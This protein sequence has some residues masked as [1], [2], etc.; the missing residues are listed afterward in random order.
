MSTDVVDYLLK[1][2]GW[3]ETIDR[4]KPHARSFYATVHDRRDLPNC[5]CNEKPPAVCL[6]EYPPYPGTNH[7]TFEVEICGEIKGTWVK[8]TAYSLSSLDEVKRGIELVRKA[9]EKAHNT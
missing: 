4:F 5:S 1:E 3:Q 7:P 8:F 2:R 9:W 6:W